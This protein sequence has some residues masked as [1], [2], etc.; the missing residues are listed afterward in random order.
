MPTD[1]ECSIGQYVLFRTV[2]GGKRYPA[3]IVSRDGQNANLVW[4]SHNVYS[5]GEA[6]ALPTF[7]RT[8]HECSE[9]LEYAS[10]NAE[11]KSSVSLHLRIFE[12]QLGGL[13][14]P[15]GED[16]LAVEAPRR[17]RIP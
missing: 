8:V 13:V 17:G 1:Q 4:H 11:P 14:K 5:C 16:S 7:T 12:L 15:G 3:K 10:L 9:A 2:P 6:P